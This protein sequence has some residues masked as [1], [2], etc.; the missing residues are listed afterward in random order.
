M[1]RTEIAPGLYVG[2]EAGDIDRQMKVE[3][4]ALLSGDTDA[5]NRISALSRR[6]Q[7]ILIRL[8][9]LRGKNGVQMSEPS[10]CPNCPA[11]LTDAVGG[12]A[13]RGGSGYGM[14]IGLT[15]LVIAASIALSIALGSMHSS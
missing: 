14:A 9:S 11:S 15:V 2:S 10:H 5:Q 12:N 6:R 7:E 8:P 1:P 13:Q 3:I 4:K